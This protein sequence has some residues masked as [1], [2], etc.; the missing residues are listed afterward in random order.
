MAR[1]AR[2]ARLDST[3]YDSTHS[4]Y[5]LPAPLI[6]DFTFLFLVG[7][8]QPHAFSSTIC[9]RQDPKVVT[10][11][12]LM[13]GH[14]VLVPL[15]NQYCSFSYFYITGGCSQDSQVQSCRQSVGCLVG[16]RCQ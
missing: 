16:H 9:L 2:L 5:P 10:L 1:L 11:N 7:K 12:I 8:L 15:M 4:T 14:T 3:R 6:N 13:T